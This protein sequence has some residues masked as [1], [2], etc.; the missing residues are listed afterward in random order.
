MA[1]NLEIQKCKIKVLREVLDI[2]P[3]Y[4]PIVG[5]VYDAEYRPGLRNRKQ[6]CIISVLDKRIILRG[7]EF[8]V[9]RC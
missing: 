6:T 7:N 9:V 3:R 8:E 4:Q 2:F 5:K 1:E